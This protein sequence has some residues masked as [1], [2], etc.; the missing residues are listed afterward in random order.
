MGRSLRTSFAF[1]A[2]RACTHSPGGFRSTIW[3]KAILYIHWRWWR[4]GGCLPRKMVR[5]PYQ[6]QERTD[7]GSLPDTV[8][9]LPSGWAFQESEL[10]LFSGFYQIIC[11]Y[12]WMP[13]HQHYLESRVTSQQ[14]CRFLV[15]M[16]FG[17]ILRNIETEEYSYY[18]PSQD[19]RLLEICKYI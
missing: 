8:D 19:N 5:Y 12:T 11:S 1:F 14:I 10:D 13:S 7:P 4:A 16:S 18:H 3:S 2:P 6:D 9:E 17:F 15:N